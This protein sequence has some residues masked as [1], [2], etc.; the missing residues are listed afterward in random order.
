MSY[1]PKNSKIHADVQ[2][3]VISMAAQGAPVLSPGG[4]TIVDDYEGTGRKIGF[5][6]FSGK[7]V[8]LPEDIHLGL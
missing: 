4:Q 5:R 2:L 1:W 7:S 3:T 6:A 8:S